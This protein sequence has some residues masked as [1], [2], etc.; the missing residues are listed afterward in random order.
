[1][2]VPDVIRRTKSNSPKI[3]ER[4]W[5]MER[6]TS[7]LP[8]ASL[9]SVFT[10]LWA[11]KLSSPDVGSSRI[12]IPSQHREA[13]FNGQDSSW[14]RLSQ[15]A[16]AGPSCLTWV[17][18]QLHSDADSAPLAPR[19]APHVDVAHARVGALPQPQLRDHVVHLGEREGGP[20]AL[21]RLR[22][23]APGQADWAPK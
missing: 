23:P 14:T 13:W 15:A 12:R 4:G 10:R 7:L 20:G 6:S 18:Q 8:L 5:W 9:D 1:M 19:H 21:E 2:V 22:G 17:P 16:H 3:S 11:V